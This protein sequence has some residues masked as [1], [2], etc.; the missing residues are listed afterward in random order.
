MSGLVPT[1]FTVDG[2]QELETLLASGCEFI[3]SG[4]SE[5]VAPRDLAGLFLG[6]GQ[7]RGEGGVVKT[8]EAD[9]PVGEMEAF[10]VTGVRSWAAE[11]KYQPALSALGKRLA[12]NLRLRAKF[13]FLNPRELARS[14]PSIESYECVA[15]QRWLIGTESL[16]N[17]CQ[18]HR[19]SALLPPSE[20]TWLLLRLGSEL[21]FS[22]ERLDRERFN[23]DDSR[24]VAC[25]LEDTRLGL[26]DAVLAARG[27]YH[28]SCR[29]RHQRLAN[30]RPV[31]DLPMADLVRHHGIGL[32]ARLHP[33]GCLGERGE[34]AKR[35]SELSALAKQ[36]WLWVEARRLQGAF[37]TPRC[38]AESPYAKCP[39][40]PK[41]RSRILNLRIFGL[42][43]ALGPEGTRC[44]RERL[45]H[46]LCLLLWPEADSGRNAMFLRA[47]AELRCSNPNFIDLVAAYERLWRSCTQIAAPS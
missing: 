41:W 1:R 28:W 29:E 25:C 43:V 21:L 42:R 12:T 6:G 4:V 36:V 11:R 23:D 30:S 34:L 37:N 24:H 45:M 9:Q 2:R 38:Y 27:Q 20:A 8:P 33:A 15:S 18:S 40:A 10:I 19:Q 39:G 14:T 47:A 7:G 31:G 46:A 32:E 16:L 3:R 17:E 44:P 13:Q 35:H 26:G 22:R 5:I